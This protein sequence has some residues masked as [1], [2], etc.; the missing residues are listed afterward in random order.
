M[1]QLSDKEIQEYISHLKENIEKHENKIKNSVEA[2]V[3]TK[4][5]LRKYEN[6][7]NNKGSN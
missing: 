6:L 2:L 7:V 1:A 5:E 3:R 4:I